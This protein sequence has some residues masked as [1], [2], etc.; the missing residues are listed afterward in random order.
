[1]ISGVVR[2][3]GLSLQVLDKEDLVLLLER[4][5]VVSK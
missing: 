4:M 3:L 1:M 2:G 5:D